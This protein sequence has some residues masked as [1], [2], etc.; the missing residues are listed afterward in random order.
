MALQEA[1]RRRRMLARKV[2]SPAVNHLRVIPAAPL[3]H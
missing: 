1:A 3:Q 2:V